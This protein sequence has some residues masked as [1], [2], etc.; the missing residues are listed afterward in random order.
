MAFETEKRTAQS[1]LSAIEDG[2]SSSDSM[3]RLIV[4]QD[5]ALIH[6]LFSWIRAHYPSSHSASDGV[7]G[8]LGE[9]VTE[10]PKAARMARTGSTDFI[11]AWFEET[12]T[13][14][15]LAGPQFIDLIVEKLEG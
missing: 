1:I 15:E 2:G 5:P 9:L 3:M 10:H 4:E 11:V 14:R 7:L 8:R 6:L 13:Y 12:H